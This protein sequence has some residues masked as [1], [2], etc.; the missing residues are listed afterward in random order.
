MP[1]LALE[2]EEE[3][4]PEDAAGV[5]FEPIVRRERRL[6]ALPPRLTQAEAEA[7]AALVAK[8]GDGA[9]WKRYEG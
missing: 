3:D 4:N 5:K 8:L 2:A 7:H 6:R 1:R 9:L